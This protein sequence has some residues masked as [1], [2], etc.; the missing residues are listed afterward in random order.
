LHDE[1][2]STDTTDWPQILALYTLLQRM[3]DSPM[4]R[5]AER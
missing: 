2:S 5:L 3:A 1:A 4:V